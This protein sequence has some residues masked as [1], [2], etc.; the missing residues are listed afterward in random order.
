MTTNPMTRGRWLLHALVILSA[1]AAQAGGFYLTEIGTPSSLGTASAGN[2]T[3]NVGADASWTNPAGMAGL[4]D[5]TI[6][7]GFQVL[8]PKIE[9]E[10]SNATAGGDD[11]GNAGAV[12]AIPSFFWVT[13]IADRWRFGLSLVAPFGGGFEFGDDFVG[14]Y[15]VTELTLSGLSLSPAVSYEVNDKVSIGAGV[16]IIYSAFEMDIAVNNDLLPLAPPGSP[17]GLASIDDAD[18]I[19][20]QGYLGL[21]WAYSDGGR[22]GVVYR[23]EM[24]VE[25]EGD[26]S[27]TGL[28]SPLLA[29]SRENQLT[30]EWDNP[31]LI[32]VGIRQRLSDHWTLVANLDWEDWSAFAENTLTIQSGPAGNPIVAPIDRNWKDTY[33]FG[34]GAGHRKG[35]QLFAF[36]I[37]Y[38]T[39][40]VD[41]EDRTMDLPSDE[42][43]RMSFVWGRDQGGRVD[44]AVAGTA[45]WLGDGKLDQEAQ[46]EHFAGEFDSNWMLFLGGTLRWV[47]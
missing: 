13:P 26:V 35:K 30:F 37:A 2:V 36:G 6:F 25:L 10:S 15:A 45:L 42:Q 32:E 5:S 40:P 28:R 44:W 11:G 22:F 19:G 20:F 7:L 41:D 21:Q 3:N 27:I 33:K 34:I 16:S 8:V 47:R 14:R 38:D 29:P 31:Q 17:D 4:E 43:F 39:S 1:T 23:S 24:D 46:D 9:F 18:D 12:A